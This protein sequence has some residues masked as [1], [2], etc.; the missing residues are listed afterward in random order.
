MTFLTWINEL[1]VKV[2]K[3][4][5]DACEPN[6]EVSEGEEVVGELNEEEKKF[7]GVMHI[8][9]KSLNEKIEKYN[10]LVEKS[11]F[12][13]L[14]KNIP[15]IKKEMGDL[16]DSI[17]TEMEKFEAMNEIHRLSITERVKP[18][19]LKIELEENKRRDII[20]IR[21]GWKIVS[22]PK[23]KGS[24]GI[25]FTEITIPSTE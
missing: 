4:D 7:V 17:N 15:K 16:Q 8:I 6:D 10:T 9:R 3:E 19:I 22:I 13:S 21:K 20:A 24:V 23:P 2:T 14:H 12:F 11:S 1:L 18:E 5:T 25:M